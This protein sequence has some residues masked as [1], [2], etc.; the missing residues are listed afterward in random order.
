MV[1]KC[2]CGFPLGEKCT[3]LVSDTN[4][5]KWGGFTRVK[6]CCACKVSALP[7]CCCKLKIA[8]KKTSLQKFEKLNLNLKKKKKKKLERRLLKNLNIF[9]VFIL[10]MDLVKKINFST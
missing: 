8:L 9:A 7:S 2:L 3:I 6:S 4:K 5:K 10:K 1:R